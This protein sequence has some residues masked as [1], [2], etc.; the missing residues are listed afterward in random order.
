MRLSPA[1][2]ADSF[3]NA[4][5]LRVVSWSPQ[6]GSA[7]TPVSIYIDYN[8]LSKGCNLSQ[9]GNN[10][11]NTDSSNDW[12]VNRYFSVMF[13][14]TA[15]QSTDFFF[16]NKSASPSSG[17]APRSQL[18]VFEGELV[19]IRTYV[20]DLSNRGEG[21]DNSGYA[22]RVQ[23]VDEARRVIGEVTVGSWMYLS[24]RAGRM[25]ESYPY[26]PHGD[27]SKYELIRSGAHKILTSIQY[28]QTTATNETLIR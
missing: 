16:T 4:L 22:V 7:G 1:I 11:N 19:Y 3:R 13:G 12:Q 6:E 28:N 8:A 17:I 20:P 14:S 27:P 25:G 2:L 18:D 24:E 23:I 15:G 9:F 5:D 10:V 26:F 21:S